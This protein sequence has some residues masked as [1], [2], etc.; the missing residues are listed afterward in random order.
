L[1]LLDPERDLDCDWTVV[2]AVVVAVVAVAVAVVSQSVYEDEIQYNRST[3][4]YYTNNRLAL[5][6]GRI[7]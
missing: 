5:H 2:A 4:R 1:E 7:P 3:Y 6:S